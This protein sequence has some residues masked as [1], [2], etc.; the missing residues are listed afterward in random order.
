MTKIAN[1]NSVNHSTLSWPSGMPGNHKAAIARDIFQ[2]AFRLE[3]PCL[4][5]AVN[6]TL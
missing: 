1:A 2:F 6:R 5:G 4:F 3:G